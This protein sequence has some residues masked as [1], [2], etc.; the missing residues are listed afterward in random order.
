MVPSAWINPVWQ[1]AATILGE[2]IGGTISVLPWRT[3]TELMKLGTYAMGFCLAFSFARSDEGARRLLDG[4]IL[5]GAFYAAY[6]FALVLMQYSQFE[7]FYDVPARTGL[8]DLSGPFVNHN[9]FATFSGLIF[10]CAGARFVSGGW[11]KFARAEGARRMA[12]GLHYLFGRG[13]LWLAAA[14]LTLSA[15]IATGSRAG[16]FATFAAMTFLLALSLRAAREKSRRPIALILALAGLG[17]VAILFVING[18]VLV[19]HLD[20]LAA[21][22]QNLR[23][24]LWQAAVGMIRGA[25]WLGLGLGTYQTAYPLYAHTVTPFIIDKAHNDY[26]ELAAGWGLPAALLWWSALLWLAGLCLRGTFLRRR[27]RIYPMLGAGATLLVG[28][29]A[30]FDF[31][32]QIP[33]IALTFAAILG[34][35]VGQAFPGRGQNADDTEVPARFTKWPRWLVRLPV[36]A[37][38]PLILLAAL[39]RLLSGLAQEEAFPATAYMAANAPLSRPA[40]QS[41][42]SILSRAPR[43]DGKTGLIQAEAQLDAGAPTANVADKIRADLSYAPAEARGWILLAAL[44]SGRNP[45]Q[46]ASQLAFAFKLAPYEY[47]LIAPR[48]LVAAPLW[49]HLPV[50]VQTVLFKDVRA[51]ALDPN[52]RTELRALLARQGG[53]A[54]VTR[55]LQGRPEDIR[56]LN[57][58]LA[59]ETLNLP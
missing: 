14:T 33:A 49:P 32:L 4:L 53:G 1:T 55:A 40:Y 29:H 47:Y 51:M 16:N 54:L 25:P 20:D 50:K 28:V 58:E 34:L 7:L 3:V 15:V 56:E 17:A 57:R 35:G 23:L 41:T 30:I 21:P 45:R 44:S 22:G 2:R 52:R 46:A 59:R 13:A 38:V 24:L 31:S 11:A 8:R 39:P 43:Q 12:V 37:P 18:S 27:N 5:A 19:S 10:I 26:L 42:A 48:T 9:S 36:A 6:G